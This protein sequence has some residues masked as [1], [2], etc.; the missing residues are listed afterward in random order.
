MLR[1]LPR[2]IMFFAFL[3]PSLA[4][5][6]PTWTPGA[7]PITGPMRSAYDNVSAGQKMIDVRD[8]DGVFVKSVTESSGVIT[9]VFQ[10]ASN[11]EQTITITLGDAADGV[12][13]SGAFTADGTMLNLTV[14]T[15]GVDSTVAVPV[16]ALLRQMGA[17]PTNLALGTRTGTTLIVTS[18]TGTDV[19]LPEASNTEAGLLSGTDHT[20]LGGIE[21]NATADQT[22][23]EIRDALQTLTGNDRLDATHIQGIPAGGTDDQNAGEVATDTTNFNLN[24]SGADTT[25]QAALDT[26]DDLTTGT[27]G[28]TDLGLANR[29]VDSLEITSSTGDN[30]EVPSATTALAGL[31]SSADKTK[32]DGIAANATANAGDVTGIDAGTGI[33]VT[34]G[35]TATPE[36]AVTNPFTDADETKLDGIAVGAQPGDVTGIDAGAGITVTDGTTP[37]PQVSVT[38]PFTDADETKLDGIAAGAEANVQADWNE[39]TTTDDAFIQNKP[40]IPDAPAS[41]A[42]A[43]GA[44]GTAPPE[45]LPGHT[46]HRESGSQA[47]DPTNGVIAF[48]VDGTLRNGDFIVFDAPSNLGSDDSVNL[49][50]NVNSTGNRNLIDREENRINETH[51]EASA[52]Y[53]IQRDSSSY[54]VLTNLEDVPSQEEIE[55]H[56]GA[57][58]NRGTK[59]GITVTYTDNADNAGQIDFNVTGGGGGTGSV[60]EVLVDEISLDW[61]LENGPSPAIQLSRALTDDDDLGLVY[62]DWREWATDDPGEPYRDNG[63]G[64]TVPAIRG[65]ADAAPVAI[66]KNP[67]SAGNPINQTVA[68]ADNR[69]FGSITFR[70]PR[71]TAGGGFSDMRMVY[72]GNH[73]TDTNENLDQTETDITVD[74]S[75]SMVAGRE[76]WIAGPVQGCA[77]TFHGEKIEVVSVDD[78]TT[79]TV[80]RGVGGTGLPDGCQFLTTSDVIEDDKR[81]FSLLSGHANHDNAVMTFR[82]LGSGGIGMADLSDNAPH[83]V[84]SGT[85]AAGTSEDASRSDHVHSGVPAPASTVVST[86]YDSAGT[87]GSHAN[88]ARQDHRHGLNKTDRFDDGE[89]PQNVTT[90]TGAAGDDDTPARRDH[91]HGGDTN[92]QRALATGTPQAVATGAGA[93]GTSTSVAREDHVHGGD[94]NT[95]RTLSDSAPENIA[96]TGAAGSSTEVSRQDHVH[97]G[98]PQPADS[99]VTETITATGTIGTNATEFAREDHR[100]GINVAGLFDNTNPAAVAETAA[101]GTATVAARR[102][103]VHVGASEQIELIDSLNDVD[104]TQADTTDLS[105]RFGGGATVYTA[106]LDAEGTADAEIN[107]LIVFQWRD[108]PAGVPNDRALGI[109]INDTGTTLP[110]RVVDP[111]TNSLTNKTRADLTR[112]EFLFLSRQDGV[113]IQLSSLELSAAMARL[114][115]G[116]PTDNQIARYD[117]ATSAWVAEDLPAASVSYST[118]NPAG[119]GLTAS[120]GSATTVARS[121]HD[122]DVDDDGIDSD[123]LAADIVLT[124]DPTAPTPA[125]GDNDT[126][127]ATTAFVATLTNALQALIDGLTTRVEAL[128]GGGTP[129]MHTRYFGMSVDQTIET[130]DLATANTS[131]T[132]EGAFPANSVN[133]YMYIGVPESVGEPTGIYFPP[134]PTNQVHTFTRQAGTIMDSNSDPHIILYSNAQVPVSTTERAVRIEHN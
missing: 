107:D 11:I 97:G 104:Y 43:T 28:A 1:N 89:A 36:V 14:T 85:A 64:M 117:S 45:R 133:S 125:D 17:G 86:T 37:T 4:A 61:D 32:L 68:V 24:L 94:R 74:S 79:I 35:A 77:T 99:I 15:N 56:V 38:N 31:Q 128:E 92:T 40:T 101:P 70:F 106:D 130:S 26:L 109:R 46:I 80:T 7:E 103:H 116:S 96:E 118:D 78:A 25:V 126:S 120:P 6:Q 58:V 66:N 63:T 112:Y 69:V 53:I 87:V 110:I 93:V 127:I 95:Q 19:T 33:T 60:G 8:L 65:I 55:D 115:P 51:L 9:V 81:T 111:L 123:A 121:D 30:V 119:V 5:A 23:G 57:L 72:I 42:L 114:L 13:T 108:N 90:G 29:D 62:L 124:G 129:A 41:W 16:P 3:I 21:A 100:H 76:Y 73:F 47:Y 39:A 50:V 131:T 71:A 132:D 98:T 54:S 122:H 49:L 113:F 102:D 10:N 20:K 18:S 105:S 88:Y 67:N 84:I 34:D 82:L 134:N 12:L 22:A 2:L 44:S 59:T 75:A 91:V 52:W 83:D 48:T 27:G